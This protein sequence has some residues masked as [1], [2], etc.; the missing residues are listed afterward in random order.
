MPKIFIKK[1]KYYTQVKGLEVINLH[2]VDGSLTTVV[3]EGDVKVEFS[4]I[5]SKTAKRLLDENAI[6]PKWEVSEEEKLEI[7]AKKFKASVA[8]TKKQNKVKVA[9][10][11]KKDYSPKLVI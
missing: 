7:T 4:S 2:F 8:R 6:V 1:P 9:G 3:L 11:N 5:H 10:L